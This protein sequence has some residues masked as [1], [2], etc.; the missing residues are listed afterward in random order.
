MCRAPEC[1]KERRE[2]IAQMFSLP[3]PSYDALFDEPSVRQRVGERISQAT[4]KKIRG[5]R[6]SSACE[7]LAPAGIADRP[8]PRQS[9]RPIASAAKDE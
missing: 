5:R 2:E 7:R 8:R 3:P 4:A 9:G 1:R 6:P